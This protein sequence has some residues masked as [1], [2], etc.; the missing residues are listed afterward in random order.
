MKPRVL[1]IY[2]IYRSFIH[3]DAEILQRHCQVEKVKWGW[4]RDAAGVRFL[5]RMALKVREADIVVV[6]FTVLDSVFVTLCARLFGTKT[7][8]FIGGHEVE[9]IREYG[10]GSMLRP[11]YRRLLPIS[12]RG[13]DCLVVPSRC[14]LEHLRRYASGHNAVVV[15]HGFDPDE[16][17]IGDKKKQAVT[18]APVVT[19]RLHLKGVIPFVQVANLLPAYRFLIIGEVQEEA[20]RMIEA[21][22]RHGN[23]VLTGPLPFDEVARVFA[24][25]R[26]YCQLSYHES[27]GCA[28]AEAMLAGC[29]P[30]AANSGAMPEVVGDVT[31]LVPFGDAETA[32]RLVAA[33]MEAPDYDPARYRAYVITR[34]HM[35]RREETLMAIVS[36]LMAG[37]KRS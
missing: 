32:A 3:R 17:V 18:V 12:F 6:W 31:P 25:S 36:E 11:V 14:S 20:R 2:D 30:V 7:L 22:S 37:R 1:F 5:L 33:A 29:F 4:S 19:E 26:V 27:F 10:Y 15:P 13:A 21:E 28:L 35:A 9:E 16:I 24:E 8:F 23:V 34:F